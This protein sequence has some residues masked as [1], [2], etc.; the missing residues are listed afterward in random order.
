MDSRRLLAVGFESWHIAASDMF[1][2]FDLFGL[3]FDN[4]NWNNL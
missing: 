2:D 3:D 4:Y 1:V